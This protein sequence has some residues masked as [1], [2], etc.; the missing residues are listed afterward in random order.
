MYRWFAKQYN[1]DANLVRL[2][3]VK[4]Q[5]MYL[6]EDNLEEDTTLPEGVV[7]KRN[8]NLVFDNLEDAQKW[9]AKQQPH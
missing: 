2:M 3:T 6:T 5:S 9:Q 7:G 1:W 4:Q 8:G